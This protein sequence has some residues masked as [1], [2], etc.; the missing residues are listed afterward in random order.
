MWQVH[1][2]VREGVRLRLGQTLTMSST[3]SLF[4]VLPLT[5]ASTRRSSSFVTYP[6]LWGKQS[7][8]RARECAHTRAAGGEALVSASR[9]ARI[10][11]TCAHPEAASHVRACTANPRVPS[12]VGPSCWHADTRRESVKKKKN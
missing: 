3:S 4:S 9:R 12:W 7:E 8:A 1:G 5:P 10:Q 6:S 2:T 11:S